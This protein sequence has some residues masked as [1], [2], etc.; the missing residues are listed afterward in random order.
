MVLFLVPAALFASPEGMD[1]VK[2]IVI[3]GNEKVSKEAIK[4]VISTKVGEK[5]DRDK[6][7]KDIKN[8]YKMGYFR[9]VQVDVVDKDGGKE[10]VFIVVE[11][12]TIGLVLFRGVKR[13]PIGK[14]REKIKSKEGDVFSEAKVKED[15]DALKKFYIS[16]GYYGTTVRAK[17]EELPKNRVKLVFVINEKRKLYVKKVRIVGNHALKTKYLKKF[18]NTKPRNIL[19]FLTGTGVLDE[20]AISADLN[21]LRLVYMDHGFM[22]AKVTGP[23]ITLTKDKKGLVVTYYVKEGPQYTV[24][25]VDV[26][27]DLIVPKWLIKKH[28]SQK[29]GKIFSA[30]RV[31]RDIEYITDLYADRGYA[32]V[33]VNPRIMP[34]KP[35]RKVSITYDITKNNLVWINRIKISGNLKTR[36]RVIRREVRLTEGGLYSATG[37]KR[38]KQRLKN[39]GY[40]DQ[41]EVKTERVGKNKMDVDIHVTEGKT[42]SIILGAGFGSVDQFVVSGVIEEKNLFG[43]GYNVYW[44]GEIGT[45]KQDYS[46]S[47]LNPHFHDGKKSVGFSIYNEIYEYDSFSSRQKGFSLTLGQSISEYSSISGTYEFKSSK[48]YD[49]DE[50]ASSYV[51]DSEGT[52][53]TSSLYLRF[54]RDTRDYVREPKHGSLFVNSYKLAVFGGDTKYISAFVDYSRYYPGPKSSRLSF[55]TRIGVIKGLFGDSVPIYERYYVGGSSTIRGFDYG[56]AGPLDE[57]D[58]P[59]GGRYEFINNF[60]VRFP[61]LRD[62]GIGGMLFV[63]VGRGSNSFAKLFSDLRMTMGF[64]IDWL[65]PMGPITITFAFN[66]FP[67]GDEDTFKTD[68]SFGRK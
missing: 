59:V 1:I 49:V 48:V 58:D 17:T 37:L 29:E 55:R 65:S 43:M 20:D 7:N 54:A 12:P 2:K 21:N 35:E 23:K 4:A 66:P 6:I 46:F 30:K 8:I 32:L 52:Y 10:V 68:F 16:S 44:S 67:R 39:T 56:E 9:D 42:G 14:L 40:F 57:E 63:D 34:Y 50:F 62:V 53:T 26:D 33:D 31:R 22:D 64:G 61:L 19:S 24:S 13:V 28:L 36:D 15:I 47:F 5:L 18:L 11:K 25:S 60:E 27:G 51:K 38:T 45:K 3:L 41:V